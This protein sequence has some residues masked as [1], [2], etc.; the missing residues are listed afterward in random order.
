[1][2]LL[3][4]HSI[5]NS[6]HV[7]H[8][9]L[10]K[11]KHFLQDTYW[12]TCWLF[13]VFTESLTTLKKLGYLLLPT[14]GYRAILIKKNCNLRLYHKLSHPGCKHLILRVKANTED[15]SI[16]LVIYF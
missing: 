5:H 4:I 12:C 14:E 7:Q 15:A 11:M 1:M 2:V 3:F 16:V 8:Y 13:S 9:F 6:L 10:M